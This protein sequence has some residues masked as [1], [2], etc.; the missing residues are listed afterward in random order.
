MEEKP[1][2]PKSDTIMIGLYMLDPKAWNYIPKLKPSA[3]GELEIPDLMNMYH[4]HDDLDFAHFDGYWIDAGS[5]FDHLFEANKYLHE[6]HKNN[7][8]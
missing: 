1:K 4:E 6:H 7:S 5:S 8:H 3:R 2:Q